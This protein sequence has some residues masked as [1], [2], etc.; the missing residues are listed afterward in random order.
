[1]KNVS[2]PPPPRLRVAQ[3]ECGGHTSAQ[4]CRF[5]HVHHVL[6]LFVG[7]VSAASV[8]KP[9][10]A[11]ER[12][13]TANVMEDDQVSLLWRWEV[14]KPSCLGEHK[15]TALGVRAWLKKVLLHLLTSLVRLVGWVPASWKCE[16]WT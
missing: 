11:A 1:M 14:K 12:L 3:L 16:L 5:H 13:K 4:D 9:C 6:K 8:R 2:C 15:A 10:C 7:A